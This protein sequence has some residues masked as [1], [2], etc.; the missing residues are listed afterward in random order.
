[1]AVY[2]VAL[3]AVTPT[4]TVTVK[5]QINGQL[6]R[7]NFREGQLVKQGD[8]LAEIDPRPYEAQLLEYQ[9]Q[10]ERDQ[11]LLA[12]ALIDLKRYQT[13]WKQNSISEQTLATQVALVEQYRGAVKLDEGLINTVKVNLIYCRITSPMDARVGLRLVDPGSFVQTTDT[14]GI[15]I[16]NSMN[17]ITVVFSVGEDNIPQI[18]NQIDS[19]Q[20][21][22]VL[23]YDRTLK[24]LL[25]LGTLL[26]IDN[27]V[28]PTTGTVKLRAEFKNEQNRLFPSQ[29]VNVKLLVE[30]LKNA[31]LVPTE[32][33]QYG[34]KSPYVYV[35][36]EDSKVKVKPILVGVTQ[37]EE[38]VVIGL[39]AGQSVVVEG[40]DKLRDG[41]D[42]IVASDPPS[43]PIRL[44][45]LYKTH[46]AI[47][48]QDI[49]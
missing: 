35:L 21:L 43:S 11:A 1:V 39:N 5:T 29:F 9:G 15:A 14:T 4:Y 20:P 48:W 12:N 2:I 44:S 17:P 47:Q 18:V 22:P 3:G 46:K 23:A 26:T 40:A 30:T 42:V 7:V 10:L 13:L 37:D 19:Q 31:I 49:A 36:G 8:L 45:A 28:D 38:T 34:A 24:Q 33:I 32:A 27:H 6:L 16:L 25:A 41:A